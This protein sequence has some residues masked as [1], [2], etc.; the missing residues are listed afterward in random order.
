ML[1]VESHRANTGTQFFTFT[2]SCCHKRKQLLTA[3]CEG[4]C[5][6]KPEEPQP[7]LC[8]GLAEGASAERTKLL[9]LLP[10]EQLSDTPDAA[11]P[12]TCHAAIPSPDRLYVSFSSY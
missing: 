8:F 10:G 11:C 3:G 7:C 9:C 4:L 12:A 6:C 1:N 2:K 5:Q